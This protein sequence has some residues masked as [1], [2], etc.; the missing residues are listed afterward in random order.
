MC[1]VITIVFITEMIS[2]RHRVNGTQKI[3]HRHGF[4]PVLYRAG[5]VPASCKWGLSDH[6]LIGV[7]VKKNNGKLTYRTIL[8]RIFSKYN[9]ENFQKDQHSL[10]WEKV[11]DEIGINEAWNIFKHLL[12]EVINK[13]VPLFKKKVRGHDCPWLNNEIK[14]KMNERDYLLRKARGAGN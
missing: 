2:H 7:I 3:T 10:P 12:I 13:H 8:E 11:S 1:D 6:D 14:S 9:E 4:T 5:V